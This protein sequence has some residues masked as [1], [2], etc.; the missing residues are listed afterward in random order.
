LIVC[1]N[2]LFHSKYVSYVPHIKYAII[3]M[4]NKNNYMIKGNV[5]NSSFIENVY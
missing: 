3:K 5:I 1:K 2:D 4:S